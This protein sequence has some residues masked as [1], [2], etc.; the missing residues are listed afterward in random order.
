MPALGDFFRLDLPR[1]FVEPWDAMLQN[2]LVSARQ[3]LGERWTSAYMSAPIWRFSLGPN[4]AGPNAISGVVMSSV[5][6]V[7]RQFPLT[8]AVA[9]DGNAVIVDHFANV[10]LFE[11]LEQLAL[12]A[13][14]D[15][16][17]KDKLEARLSDLSFS[18]ATSR[19]LSALGRGLTYETPN[20]P[21]AAMAAGFAED[22][23]RHPSVWSAVL[24]ET[25]R[26][27]LCEGL[28]GAREVVG[29]FDMTAE[30]WS[31]PEQG[32]VA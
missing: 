24:G 19:S 29:L 6:R 14:D 20:V 27:M 4:Q 21:A 23:V 8:L 7:G 3:S 2:A 1:S 25:N 18:P 5:D 16:M 30:I 32:Q 31:D 17:T 10:A 28:P 15:G 26:I 13:L 9:H 11:A 22:R 12:D